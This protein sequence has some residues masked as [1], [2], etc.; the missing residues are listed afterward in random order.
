MAEITGA[1]KPIDAPEVQA[2]REERKRVAAKHH[3][4]PLK[5]DFLPY[6]DA[7]IPQLHQLGEAPGRK[8]RD[9]AEREWHEARK[10]ERGG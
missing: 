10:A 9:Q 5:L 2:A 4:D 8:A 3:Y 7:R 1:F 6:I